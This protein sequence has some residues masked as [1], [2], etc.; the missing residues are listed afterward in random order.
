MSHLD[1]GLNWG[2]FSLPV[3]A[4]LWAKCCLEG[5][6][7]TDVRGR[8]L[9]GEHTVCVLAQAPPINPC[10]DFRIINSVG[11]GEAGKIHKR[12][13]PRFQGDCRA[14]PWLTSERAGRVCLAVANSPDVWSDRLLQRATPGKQEH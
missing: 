5:S 3:F 9:W 13:C 11:V 8:G 6:K 12:G 7:S 4:Q 1:K 10:R 14:V 2:W